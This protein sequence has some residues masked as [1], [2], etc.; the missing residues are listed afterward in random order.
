M[1]R[2]ISHCNTQVTT[3]ISPIEFKMDGYYQRYLTKNGQELAYTG[4]EC[5]T[6]LFYFSSTGISVSVPKSI[7]KLLNKGFNELS[8]DVLDKLRQIIPTGEY[9]VLLLKVYPRLKHH[10]NN[11]EY[12]KSGSRKMIR[13]KKLEEHI[14]PLQ[15]GSSLD[16]NTI[17][18][19]IQEIM[20]GKMPT[21]LSISFLDIKYPRDD[22][23]YDEC[24]VLTH[25]L[26]DGHHK[27]YASAKAKKP[28][29]LISFLSIDHSFSDSKH[30]DKLLQI[31]K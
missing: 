28:I 10:F 24:W 23:Y 3:S 25:F 15:Y 4:I 18:Q 1:S 16:K 7:S 17:N 30:M 26:L 22:I 31:L 21:A 20:S 12:Y 29:S 27:I 6:C 13:N 2:L 9:I 19:Y 14:V 5:E 11:E 8:Q